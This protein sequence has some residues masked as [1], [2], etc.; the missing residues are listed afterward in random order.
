[1]I[2][3]G[4]CDDN[5]TVLKTL[6]AV[7]N[8]YRAER[9]LDM[10]CA[11]FHSPLDLLAKIERGVRFDV[12]LM[13]ILMPGEDGIEA[14]KEI[15]KYDRNVKIIFLT[16][17]AEF[18]VQSYEVEAFYYM[19]KPLRVDSVFSLLDKVIAVCEQERTSRLVIRCKDG[20]SCIEPHRLE[21]CEVIHRTLY[22]HL[23]DGTV[24]ESIGCMDELC[25]ELES[26]G[27]FLR[28]HRSYM[29]NLAYV[30]NLSY[31]ALTLSCG[32][33]IPIPRGRYQEIK[34]AYLEYAFQ[35]KRAKVMV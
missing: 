3:I 1:M 8:Q 11:A 28:P 26:F 13:D 5:A 23:L 7:L 14:A 6:G 9:G 10:E 27:C 24:A 17:S 21:Y 19:L 18:A 25:R 35:S 33:E 32:V 30:Q 15:R 34:K 29:V 12:L 31:R 2:H 22:I 4:Y 20:I 16:S